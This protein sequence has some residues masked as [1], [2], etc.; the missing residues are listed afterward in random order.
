MNESGYQQKCTWYETC[1]VTSP[2]PDP[3]LEGARAEGAV[4]TRRAGQ[5]ELCA[6]VLCSELS[7]SAG[8]VEQGTVNVE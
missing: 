4:G 6:G 5:E 7:A 2:H 1:P 3:L 8:G